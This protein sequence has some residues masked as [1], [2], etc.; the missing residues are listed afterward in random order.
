MENTILV[1]PSKTLDIGLLKKL[2]KHIGVRNRSGLGHKIGCGSRR[3][4]GFGQGQER[5]QGVDGSRLVHGAGVCDEAGEKWQ[6]MRAGSG[7][8][9]WGGG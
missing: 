6:K 7:G 1:M 8:C 4:G 2:S 5:R 9:G 3:V